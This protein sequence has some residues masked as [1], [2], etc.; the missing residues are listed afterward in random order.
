MRV[1]GEGAMIAWLVTLQVVVVPL[2]VEWRR[3]DGYESMSRPV[4]QGSEEVF[5]IQIQMVSKSERE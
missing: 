3:P 2:Q 5:H 1:N 4:E